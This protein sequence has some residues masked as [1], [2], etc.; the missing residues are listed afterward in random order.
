MTDLDML[1]QD[2]CVRVLEARNQVQE[3]LELVSWIDEEED[4]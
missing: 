1:V 4:D 2:L 3:C